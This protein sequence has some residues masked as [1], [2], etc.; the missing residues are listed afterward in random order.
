MQAPYRLKNNFDSYCEGV[1]SNS[2]APWRTHPF[3]A[4][5][6]SIA[7]EDLCKDELIDH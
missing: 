2:T 4:K 7:D 5:L 6:K 1:I 3:E